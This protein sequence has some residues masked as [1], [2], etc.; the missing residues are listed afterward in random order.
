MT[1]PTATAARSLVTIGSGAGRAGGGGTGM[2]CPGLAGS[3]GVT[4][5]L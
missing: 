2:S 1:Q 5:E 3:V 4:T